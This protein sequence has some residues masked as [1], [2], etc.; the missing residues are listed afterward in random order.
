MIALMIWQGQAVLSLFTSNADVIAIAYV[1]ICIIFPSYIFSMAYENM[2][3]Y[4]RGFSISLPP[5]L[6]TVVGVCGV[7]LLWVAFI[8]PASPTFA[9][10]MAAYPVS[11]G[12]TALLIAGALALFRPAAIAQSVR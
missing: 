10:I 4:L 5:S 2:S 3:G 9:T 8:L 6:L 1:R 7:R 12:T 11:L